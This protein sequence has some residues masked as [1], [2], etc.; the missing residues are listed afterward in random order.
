MLRDAFF[1]KAI[2][3]VWGDIL[4]YLFLTAGLKRNLSLQISC[5]MG[6]G[7]LEL[8]KARHITFRSRAKYVTN[9]LISSWFKHN[10]LPSLSFPSGNQ[11]RQ[12]RFSEPG[13]QPRIQ[14]SACTF[15]LHPKQECRKWQTLAAPLCLLCWRSSLVSSLLNLK[16]NDKES[17]WEAFVA[18]HREMHNASIVFRVWAIVLL[19]VS[20]CSQPFL[21]GVPKCSWRLSYPPKFQPFTARIKS[22]TV[23]NSPVCGWN[24]TD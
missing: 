16:E 6:I 24:C 18:I 4:V 19:F 5:M 22:F 9:Q 15:V 10:P 11:K 17:Y 1:L 7:W 23:Y 2:I 12:S 14:S 21:W 20:L 3:Y 13:I 8:T